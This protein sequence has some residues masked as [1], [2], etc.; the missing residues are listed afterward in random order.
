MLGL[1]AHARELEIAVADAA[2]RLAVRHCDWLQLYPRVG[3]V[4]S[5]IGCTPAPLSY[6]AQMA[7]LSQPTSVRL[8]SAR[9]HQWVLYPAGAVLSVPRAVADVWVAEGRALIT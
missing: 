3:L 5:C 2:R 9:W 8:L 6:Q 7:Q 4:M 1:H